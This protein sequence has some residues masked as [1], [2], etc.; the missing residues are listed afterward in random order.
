[1]PKIIENLRTQLLTETKRQIEESGYAKTTVRSVASACGVGVGTVYNY[2][3]SKD[4]LIASFMLEDWQDCLAQMRTAPTDAPEPFLRHLY[5][6][7]QLFMGKHRALFK[8]PDAAKPF[9][10][11][12]AERHGMLREQMADVLAPICQR[13]SV[14]D[15]T[16]LASFVAEALLSWTV[17]G[18]PFPDLAPIL[19]HLMK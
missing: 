7:L 15:K 16:F 17:A 3:S 10:S 1:M 19:C 18:T 13:A 6:T 9:A 5:D 12:F 14:P 11:A 8:D 2:F 4:M